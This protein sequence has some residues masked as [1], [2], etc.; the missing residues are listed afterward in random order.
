M[1]PRSFSKYWVRGL[2]V[3]GGIGFY[4][5]ENLQCLTLGRFYVFQPADDVHSPS[6]ATFLTLSL[7]L[8]KRVPVKNDPY[9]GLIP[10]YIFGAGITS[11]HFRDI[12]ATSEN[13]NKVI[14]WNEKIDTKRSQT[15]ASVNF[16]FGVDFIPFDDSIVYV[17]FQLVYSFSQANPVFIPIVVGIAMD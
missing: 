3:S 2:N 8:K 6:N 4:L 17:Q 14:L 7:N 16:G 5:S 15:G 11:I 9:A 12:F 1:Q 10:Y 13:D